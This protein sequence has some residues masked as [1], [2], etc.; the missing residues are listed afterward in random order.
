M[1]R[2]KIKTENIFFLERLVVQITRLGHSYRIVRLIKYPSVALRCKSTL[3][4]MSLISSM[5]CNN[6]KEGGVQIKDLVKNSVVCHLYSKTKTIISFERL[7]ARLNE[8]F[9]VV[10]I[11]IVFIVN[12]LEASSL[13]R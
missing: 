13:I 9:F 10:V 5:N 2:N 12:Q 3:F 8:M 4:H 1:I 7:M 6:K 11:L